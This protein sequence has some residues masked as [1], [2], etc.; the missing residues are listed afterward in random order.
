MI[1]EWKWMESPVWCHDG[2]IAVANAPKDKVKLTF[3]REASLPDPEARL[4]QVA[5][6]RRLLG[7]K[8]LASGQ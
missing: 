8:V 2:I 3:S 4:S 5:V 7:P 6:K 1:E